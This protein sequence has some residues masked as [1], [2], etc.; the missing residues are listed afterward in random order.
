MPYLHWETDSRRARM[1]EV[2]KEV[3]IELEEKDP[4]LRR[5]YPKP[6]KVDEKIKA[7]FLD[8]LQAT[9]KGTKRDKRPK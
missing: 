6:K 3:T 2:V 7:S 9:A 4:S 8:V 5:R 1:A